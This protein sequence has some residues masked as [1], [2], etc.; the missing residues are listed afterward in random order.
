MSLKSS[1]IDNHVKSSKHKAGKARLEK[2]EARE[3]DIA[4]AIQTMW[5]H[6]SCYSLTSTELNL[7]YCVCS[8]VL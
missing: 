5:K 4:S 7:P 6:L 2:K 1:V 3:A 8:T